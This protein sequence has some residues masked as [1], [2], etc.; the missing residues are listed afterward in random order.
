MLSV[1]YFS[2]KGVSNFT[3]KYQKSENRQSAVATTITRQPQNAY[4]T[5][6]H[7]IIHH[8]VLKI[9]VGDRI[10]SHIAFERR[11][12]GQNWTK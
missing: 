9:H 6:T 5:H 3:H 1:Y 11:S 10:S 2:F 7:T 4:T 8:C 12:I